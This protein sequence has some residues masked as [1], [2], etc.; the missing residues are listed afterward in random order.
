MLVPESRDL[1]VHWSATLVRS[2]YEQGCRH[3]I[4]SPGS[5]STPLTLAFAAHSGFQ[6]QVIIDERSA[7]F[8]A[9]GIAKA[10]GL[11]ACLVC[12]SGTAA[13][14]YYPALI[15]ATQ[16]GVPLIVLSADRPPELR[17]TGASQTIDQIKLFGDLPVFFHEAGMPANTE[18]AIHRIQ[19]LGRQAARSAKD[20]RGIVHINL[21]FTKPFEPRKEYLAALSSY[22]AEQT[23]NV[24]S[25]AHTK[26]YSVLPDSIVKLI[27]ESKNT[28]IISGPSEPVSP[29]VSLA[30]ELAKRLNA[31]LL[32]EPGSCLTDSEQFISGFDGFLRSEERMSTLLPDLIIR[33]GQEPV[34]KALQQMLKA[35]NNIPQIRIHSHAE[36]GDSLH[37]ASQHLEL[38]AAPDLSGVS[39][40]KQSDAWFNRWKKVSSDFDAF[41]NNSLIQQKA[42]TDAHVCASINRVFP[43]QVPFFCSNSFPIRDLALFS[44]YRSR[45]VYANRG[46]AGIDGITST[47]AG[48][49]LGSGKPLVLLTGDIAFLHDSN[50]LLINKKLDQ[51]LIIVLFNNGGGTIFRMLPVHD[52][53]DEYLQYFETPQQVDI[54]ALC[55]AHGIAYESVTT[56]DKLQSALEPM[57]DQ[58][59]IYVFDCK[60]SADASMKLR[61]L[62][63]QY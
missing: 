8:T 14:N 59:G 47:A 9:L 43:K 28:L 51:P 7:A 31:P 32:A 27:Q 37:T 17:Q 52:F 54:S 63:W 5:R 58:S 41:R 36:S 20:E 10:T 55:A 60:T 18:D 42:F 33:T 39:L 19:F 53:K 23:A 3:A 61:H 26:V 12:T 11:P 6:K 44:E 50:G 4:I 40:H 48:I 38:P 49:T 29:S 24:H 56:V 22:F 45:M 15:E 30:A 46:A 62:L 35:C 16:S 2:L 1:N 25:S 34:S 57:P 21:P 13:A